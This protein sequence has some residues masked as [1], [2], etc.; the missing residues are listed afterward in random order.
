MRSTTKYELAIAV[1]WLVFLSAGCDSQRAR[2]VL[3]YQTN[4]AAGGA[5]GVPNMDD[6]VMSINDRLGRH[7]KATALSNGQVEV[8]LYRDISDEE[9]DALKMR[10]GTLES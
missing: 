3:T 1:A 5:V 7:G 8:K 6:L 9:L 10:I 2:V 4:P